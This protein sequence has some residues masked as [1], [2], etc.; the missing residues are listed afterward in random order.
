MRRI[1]IFL[2]GYCRM[3]APAPQAAELLDLLKRRGIIT[4]DAEFIE[5]RIYFCASRISAGGVMRECSLA[6]I[7]VRR[8]GEY[9][10]PSLLFRYRMR[11]GVLV[12][13]ICCIAIIFFSGRVIWDI[14]VDGNER[15]TDAEVISQLRE[16]GLSIGKV[17][18]RVDTAGVE[19]LV[20][21]WSDD[22]SWISI[23]IIGTVAEV[24]IRESEPIPKS[25]E[26]YDA[27]NIVAAK[28]GY[29]ER[30][31]DTRGNVVAKIGDFVREGE[32]LVSGLYD[33]QTEGLRYT[34]AK[35][36][37]LART[38]SVFSVSIPF[39]YEKKV[40]TGRVFTE[41]YLIFF[42]KEIKIF[43]KGGNSYD[44]CDTIDTVE[45]LDLFGAGGLPVAIRTVKYLEYTTESATRNED[46][47]GEL[48]FSKL[49]T[50]L[51][52]FSQ[53][54][55]LTKKSVTFEITDKEYKLVCRIEAIEDIAR[56]QEIEIN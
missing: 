15:L 9:G 28:D 34:S 33:S 14:R 32:L 8:E 44:S 53:S 52:S 39:E 26:E 47:A 31:E 54:A 10:V 16:C 41:K 46:E 21:I 40:Y 12:G 3:S 27:A 45:K 13:I 23:N 30:F 25:P 11:F 55:E 7:E 56:V 24:Q 38:E 18:S 17:R 6:G 49:E 42:E 48:A 20:T 5:D 36:R 51:M 2:F 22:I 43:T 1:F 29:I 19:N 50:I 4:F 35:G 37:V